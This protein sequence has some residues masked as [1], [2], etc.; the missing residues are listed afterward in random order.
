VVAFDPPV[1]AF[2]VLLSAYACRPGLGSEPGFGWNWALEL[3]RSGA[4][5][6]VLTRY[7]N[8]AAIESVAGE[9]AHAGLHFIYVEH[10]PLGR[11]IER[12][13]L[14]EYW[15][16]VAWQE[17]AYKAAKGLR[18]Q[19]DFDVVHHVSYGSLHIGS[20]LWRLK[21]PFIFGP[22]GG[23]QI[24][25]AGFRRH[26]HGGWIA[27]CIRSIVARRLYA[28][29]LNARSTVRGATLVLVANRDTEAAVRSLGAR[30]IQV[31]TDV[32]LPAVQIGAHSP[33]A[34][35]RDEPLRILW[36]A[37][38]RP[39][40]GLL[41]A[42]EAVSLIGAETPWKLTIVGDG[43][44]A[45]ML[46]RWVDELGLRD[47]VEWRGKL[48][49]AETQAS[50][51][52]A[53]LFLFTS[54]RDTGGGQLLEAMARGLPILTLDHHGGATLVP[55]SAGVKIP[56]TTPEETAANLARAIERLAADR[57]SLMK[58]GEAA[59]EVARQ[60]TWDRKAADA[61][62]I[63]G[64]LVKRGSRVEPARVAALS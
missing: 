62:K 2:R 19:V 52:R 17:A 12:L 1:P 50:Y 30:E 11:I 31:M 29:V 63:Y 33:V 43:E 60:H 16:H 15:K 5:V 32:G 28:Y 38:L 37:G 57:A 27:E 46:P 13:P 44:Q 20:R 54:L 26:F 48:P 18:D 6:W 59:I 49:W 47:N 14:G 55:N 36:V 23:G 41:L 7:D 53:D 45:G 21:R 51:D 9:A 4:E 61:L 39:R 8:K 40:K 3:A 64:R 25:P 35:S 24:A 42:L 10:P 22:V 56:V 58:M 34:S